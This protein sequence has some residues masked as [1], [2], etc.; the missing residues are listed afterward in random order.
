MNEKRCTNCGE[1]KPSTTEY[2]SKKKGCKNGLNSKCRECVKVYMREYNKQ[3]YINNKDYHKQKN[4]TWTVN[5]RERMTELRKNWRKENYERIKESEN[6]RSRQW[7]DANPDYNKNW[8]YNNK[9]RSKFLTRRWILNNSKKWVEIRKNNS[10]KRKA[11]ELSLPSTFTKEEWNFCKDY[12]NSE[13]AYCGIME[14]SAGTLH[15]DHFIPL[16]KK[17]HYAIYNIIPACSKCNQSK[18]NKQF[19]EWFP[20]QVFYTEERLLNIKDYLNLVSRED[21]PFLMENFLKKEA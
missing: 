9:N 4:V 15:Q 7:R 6:E 20:L 12:F 10:H 17:G 18:N 1:D 16:S 3:H 13:C 5:N 11:R 2:F 14:E 19:N 8:Y 21:N